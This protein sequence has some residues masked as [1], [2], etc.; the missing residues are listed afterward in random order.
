MIRSQLPENKDFHLRES[1]AQFMLQRAL[2][3]RAPLKLSGVLPLVQVNLA[4]INPRLIKPCSNIQFTKSVHLLWS[5]LWGIG[6]F[7]HISN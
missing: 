4:P 7:F 5:I 2:S 3:N 1:F 6:S